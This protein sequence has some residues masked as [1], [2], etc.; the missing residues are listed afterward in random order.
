MA[1]TV[2]ISGILSSSNQIDSPH[3]GNELRKRFK[4]VFQDI[5]VAARYFTIH[6]LFIESNFVIETSIKNFS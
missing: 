2:D 4:K 6:S 3:C 1:R 5:Q